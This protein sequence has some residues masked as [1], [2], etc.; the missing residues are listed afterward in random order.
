MDS[1]DL[2]RNHCGNATG[3]PT[4]SVALF[5]QHIRLL[6]SDRLSKSEATSSPVQGDGLY[7]GPSI[8][9][10]GVFT[11]T[12]P[13]KTTSIRILWVLWTAHGNK[14]AA[15]CWMVS[16]RDGSSGVCAR[17]ASRVRSVVDPRA[18]IGVGVAQWRRLR[19]RRSM[20][21]YILR[22]QRVLCVLTRLGTSS[23]N[24]TTTSTSR[25]VSAC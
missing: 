16:C 8:C 18:T 14:H 25:G 4:A 6:F 1:L 5:P 24:H 12:C 11:F 22:R 15:W 19:L 13:P 3:S 2:A 7:E 17:R 23:N 9:R 10:T 20:P 21:Q